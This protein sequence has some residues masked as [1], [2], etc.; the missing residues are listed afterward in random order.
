MANGI[1]RV[2]ELQGGLVVVNNREILAELSLPI[3]GYMTNEPLNKVIENYRGVKQAVKNLGSALS[4]PYLTLQVLPG[5]FLPY[6]R[7]TFQG[8]ADMKNRRIVDSIVD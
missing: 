4:D 7:I 5:T 3:G 6:F 8:L 1:N 2:I